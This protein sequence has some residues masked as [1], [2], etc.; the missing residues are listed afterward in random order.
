MAEQL[1]VPAEFTP[2]ERQQL[3]DWLF[4]FDLS[5]RAD[6]L[7]EQVHRLAG[8]A[9]V[10]RRAA[11]LEMIKIDLEKQ[12]QRGQ[13]LFV[14]DYLALCPEVGNASTVP[15]ELLWAEY[16]VRSWY[17]QTPAWAEYAQRFP[18]R[19][20]EL[21]QVAELA[22][23]GMSQDNS[24]QITVASP[25]PA[26]ATV[27]DGRQF[28]AEFGRYRL[29]EKLGQGGMGSVYR[30]YD[31]ELCREVALKVLDCR[32]DSTAEALKRF[33]QE[34]RLIAKLN[35]PNICFIYDISKQDGRHYISMTYIQG[36]PL[37]KC[38]H[39]DIPFPEREAALVVQ[40]LA[41][42]LQRVHD[43]DVIHRD[44]KPANVILTPEGEPVILDFGLA[45]LLASPE[46][47]RLS[48]DGVFIGTPH[49]ASPEQA[50]HTPNAVGKASDIYNLG[51]LL[52]ELLTGTLPFTGSLDSVLRQVLTE[53]P[54][55]PTRF[56]A[57]VSPILDA[58]CLKAMSKRPA[59]RFSS[60]GEM[61]AALAN[62][63]AA[64]QN[65]TEHTFTGPEALDRYAA[66]NQ[67]PQHAAR[68]IRWHQRQR[69]GVAA[70]A[71]CLSVLLL[72]GTIHFSLRMPA[73][74]VQI[75]VHDVPLN[76]VAIQVDGKHITIAKD[77]REY[78]FT[79]G[80]HQLI[81]EAPGFRTLTKDFVIKRGNNDAIRVWLE[82]LPLRKPAL[83]AAEPVDRALPHPLSAEQAKQFQRRYAASIKAKVELTNSIGMEF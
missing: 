36:Q 33:Q 19:L 4:D 65:E 44:L 3:D 72:L 28:A 5:W 10:L 71:S 39:R 64:A 57:N 12:W 25:R 32:H 16:Q 67:S 11:V 45:R 9:S 73:G 20:A 66:G 55:P 80:K 54:P 48:R 76:R 35:D 27:S 78:R 68:S 60:M 62:F 6:L 21:R 52:Y 77:R 82:P 43:R 30:A 63:L 42:T 49:Y 79:V 7:R 74:I 58:I 56:R 24:H 29:L 18:G 61:A 81:V 37:S 13:R 41:Q 38:I 47:L 53:E 34:A 1:V 70:L 59:D 40:K 8:M 75:E 46:D 50:A 69:L 26:E 17:D 23:Q 83:P 51:V 15:A 31:S 14:E 22:P 2:E